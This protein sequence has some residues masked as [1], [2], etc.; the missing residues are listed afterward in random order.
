MRDSPV[1]NKMVSTTDSPNICIAGGR[2]TVNKVTRLQ[3]DEVL[4]LG[5][6][7]QVKTGYNFYQ[8]ILM[9]S[10]N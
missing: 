9:S 3:K 2:N 8:I 6:C 5:K 10:D 4:D 7:L 1:N